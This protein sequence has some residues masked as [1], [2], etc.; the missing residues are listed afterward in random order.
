M[1]WLSQVLS[2]EN[3]GSS[4]AAIVGSNFGADNVFQDYVQDRLEDAIHSQSRSRV[5]L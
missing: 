3:T 5:L 1:T 2:T 4:E